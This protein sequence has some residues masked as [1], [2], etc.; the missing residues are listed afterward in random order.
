M[1]DNISLQPALKTAA[2]YKAAIDGLLA[3]MKRL[4]ALMQNDQTEI[5]RLKAETRLIAAHTDT[6]L[7]RLEAQ[8]NSLQAAV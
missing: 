8:V 3:E 1:D 5:D 6:V 2:D 7:T 4:N